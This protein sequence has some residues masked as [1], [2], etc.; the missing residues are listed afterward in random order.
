MRGVHN[1]FHVSLLRGWLANGVHAH[2]ISIKINGEAE[3]KVSKIKGYH[4][5]QGEMRYLTLFVDFD[6]SE[7]MWLSTA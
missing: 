5:H 4:E 6:S 7:D 2:V 3:Y 1:V